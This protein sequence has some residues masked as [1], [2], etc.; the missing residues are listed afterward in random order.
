MAH[1]VKERITIGWCDNG[2]VEGR[3]MSGIVNTVIEAPKHKLNIVNTL[4]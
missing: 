2:M 4:S 3:F 1:S